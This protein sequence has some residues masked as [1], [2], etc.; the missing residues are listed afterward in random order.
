M[1]PNDAGPEKGAPQDQEESEKKEK[2]KKEEGEKKAEK[3]G[4]GEKDTEKKEE[5][6]EE[7]TEEEGKGE[8][9]EE[10]KPEEEK[11][12]GIINDIIANNAVEEEAE[13]MFTKARVI[14]QEEFS[15]WNMDNYL[16]SKFSYVPESIRILVE[17][18]IVAVLFMIFPATLAFLENGRNAIY[19]PLQVFHNSGSGPV[20]LFFRINFVLLICYVICVTVSMLARNI[21]YIMVTILDL[22]NIEPDEY[23]IET[24]QVIN[25]TS[26]CW[27]QSLTGLLIFITA[28]TIS[29]PYD[30]DNDDGSLRYKLITMTLMYSIFMAVIFVEK[31]FMCFMISEIRRKEY[32]NRIWDINYKTFVFKKLAAI[33]EESPSERKTLAETM[34][35]DFDP[36]FY[37]KH[38]DLKLNSVDAAQTVAESIFGFLEIQ[39]LIYE[40]LVKFFPSNHKE[41]YAY[42]ADC[43]DVGEKDN[44]PITFEDLKARAVALYKERTDISKTLQSRDIVINKLDIILVTLAMYF[45]AVLVMI[46]MKI[47]YVEMLA[48]ILPS[49]VTFSWIFSDTIKEIY[50]C[51]V[52]LLVNHPYDFGDRVV[53]DG[54]ELYVSSVDLL[55]STFIGVNG[56]QVFIPTATLFRAKIHNI[57]RSGKQCEEVE[58][59]VSKDTSFN[60]ALKLRE[61]LTEEL[62]KLT[63]SFSGEVYIRGFKAEG[64]S[65]KIS[66]AIQHQSNF[67]DIQKRH[68]RR[69]EIVNILEKE[70]KAS[71]MA[72]LNSF[73]FRD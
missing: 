25:S 46:L 9:E 66:F 12:E 63:K 29:Q 44:P 51:F 62:A 22:F 50:N 73:A 38:S 30:F 69:V 37:L 36:G 32:R 47:N 17:I 21:L 56:R 65:V 55:S 68:E 16:H 4:E 41:V 61:K 45:G 1:A 71:G 10:K 26:W 8:G 34:E 43:S 33:S 48:A 27:Q 13:M 20:Y 52:F 15:F 11:K 3:K 7:K 14:D 2:M 23:M 39:T 57:R 31:F 42:L 64:D 24:I 72:Y 59:L 49:V 28:A 53:I 5:G 67:Q 60:T 19:L 18:I 6:G 70:L 35:A 54:E 58:V 40:D